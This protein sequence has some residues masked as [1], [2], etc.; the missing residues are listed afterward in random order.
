MNKHHP[1]H[2]FA[3]AG[4]LAARYRAAMNRKRPT[5]SKPLAAVRRRGMRTLRRALAKARVVLGV[6]PGFRR[7][8][9]AN[10]PKA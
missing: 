8:R 1:A 3:L 7:M 2:A 5:R 6:V 10:D 4:R 9:A